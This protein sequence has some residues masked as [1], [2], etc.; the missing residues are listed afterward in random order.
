M[1]DGDSHRWKHHPNKQKAKV[2]A[3]A[4][5]VSGEGRDVGRVFLIAAV[6]VAIVLAAGALIMAASVR[7]NSGSSAP[8]SG[9]AGP[10]GQTV[11]VVADEWDFDPSQLELPPGEHTVRLINDGE[12]FH[13]LT[14]ADG[15][16]VEVEPGETG[17]VE[18]TIPPGGMEF[19]C[20]LAGHRE[21]GME[22]KVLVAGSPPDGSEPDD[23]EAA[24][25]PEVDEI[26]RHPTDL[27][28][29]AD[30]TLYR[31]GAYQNPADRT[32]PI[33]QEVHFQIEETVAEVLPGTTMNYWTFDATVPGPMLRA[34]A[35]D[36]IDFFLHNP[37]DSAMPH[38]VDFHAVTGPG[39]G[40]VNLDAAPGATSNLRARLEKPGIYIYHCAFP[41]I[42]SHIAHGMYGLIVVEPEGGLPEVDHEYYVMQSE[43]YTDRGGDLSASSLEDAGHLTFSGAYGNLEEPTFV[44]FN[45]RPG[46]VTDDRALGVFGDEPVETGDTARVYVGDIGPNLASSFHII[47]EIFDTVYVDGSFDLTNHNV[48]STLVPSGGAIGVELTFDVPGDYL[49]VDHSIFRVHKGAAGQIHVQGPDNPDVYEPVTHSSD[50]RSEHDH[51][52]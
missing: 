27:P 24:R 2:V 32:G 15:T 26:S 42:P 25:T 28:D 48:Q 29:S 12:L 7:S 46:A 9:A 14:F 11:E 39:G 40:S 52:N 22:G 21:A 13:D 38:N 10:A 47:G 3:M 50:V 19:Y 37:D 17:E 44:T 4:E 23:T 36:T 43:F 31:D 33:T 6:A 16:T 35:G 49:M 34:R 30:Y 5:A 45:G 18:V 51:D 8:G 1:L 20:S 41:D